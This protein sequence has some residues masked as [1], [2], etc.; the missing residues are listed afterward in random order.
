RIAARLDMPAHPRV[1]RVERAELFAAYG[2]H[3]DD[4]QALL[5]A[6]GEQPDRPVGEP[7]RAHRVDEPLHPLAIRAPRDRQAEAVA[8]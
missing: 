6:A 7:A 1:E 4:A 2:L 5:L 3:A 8:V